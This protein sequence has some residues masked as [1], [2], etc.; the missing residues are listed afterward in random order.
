VNG[1]P[2]AAVV[3]VDQPK[4]RRGSTV[5]ATVTVT[6]P[7]TRVEPMTS[8]GT[9]PADGTAVHI[10]EQRYHSDIPHIVWRW[11]G[12]TATLGTGLTLRFLADHSGTLE[13]MV[14]DA[15][16]HTVTAAVDVVVQTLAVGVDADTTQTPTFWLSELTQVITGKHPDGPTKLFQPTGMPTVGKYAVPAGMT[17]HYT[18]AEMPTEADFRAFVAAL[19]G[20]AW[21]SSPQEM[22][23]KL[24]LADARTR[25]LTMAGWMDEAPDGVELVPNI[26][27]SWQENHG[28]PWSDWM[29]T[30]PRISKVGVDMY[31]GGQSGYRP[32]T[33]QLDPAMAAAQAAGLDLVVPEFGV[34]VPLAPTAANFAERA[35][36][37][38]TT[39]ASFQDA[40]VTYAAWWNG[41]PTSQKGTFRLAPGDPGYDV[42]RGGMAA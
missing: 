2:P 41:P 29:F 32:I 1:S 35:A 4:Y 40:G 11:R 5:S 8:D 31:V 37:I 9:D 21:I 39:L 27:A 20:P 15:Q 7:D 36:W 16:N 22:D 23:R 33:T 14:T 6:D 12:T 30:H 13:A 10:V 34:V 38:T 24:S 42:V 28:N 19:T 25:V 3:S 17:T 18:F 26:T